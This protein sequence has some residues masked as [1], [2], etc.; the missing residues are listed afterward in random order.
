MGRGLHLHGVWFAFAWGVV[1]I[2]MVVLVSRKVKN[3]KILFSV[4]DSQKE[5]QFCQHNS[6]RSKL[7]AG[8]SKNRDFWPGFPA[9]WHQPFPAPWT[10]KNLDC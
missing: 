2:C 3:Q 7:S 10:L 9:P 8:K 4:R 1:F 5:V 6:Y